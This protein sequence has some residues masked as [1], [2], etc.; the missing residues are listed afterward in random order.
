M[1]YYCAV[2]QTCGLD[3]LKINWFKNGFT[4]MNGTTRTCKLVSNHS[5][6]MQN[7]FFNI[8]INEFIELAANSSK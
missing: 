4:E 8:M 5:A 2:K 7:C 1:Y 3:V 6:I